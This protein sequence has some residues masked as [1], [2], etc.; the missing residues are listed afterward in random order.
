MSW[1][2]IN[3]AEQH[4]II[5]PGRIPGSSE[6]MSRCSPVAR[7]R[8]RC[9]GTTKASVWR[10]YK[11]VGVAVLQ[12]RRCGGTTKASVWRYYKGV[13]VAVLQKRPCGGTTK[14]SVWRY[15]KGVG[16][17]VLQRRRCG[18]TTKTSVWRYYKAAST[19]CALLYIPQVV[20]SATAIRNHL[21]RCQ[22]CT[23]PAN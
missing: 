22:T 11:G 16:V 2:I 21:H 10:Y 18:G 23:G 6:M 14:A 19:H 9:G 15:Y 20:E 12:R 5:L 13:G 4:S 7:Q 1:F 3:F 8:S 17:A